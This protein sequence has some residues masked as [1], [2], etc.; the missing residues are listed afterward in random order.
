MQRVEIIQ[1]MYLYVIL[2][3]IQMELIV[4]CLVQTTQLQHM[5]TQP[6]ENAKVDSFSNFSD[7]YSNCATCIGGS[8]ND[9]SS[10]SGLYYLQNSTCTSNCGSG[11]YSNSN[12]HQCYTNPTINFVNPSST[13]SYL[14]TSTIPFATNS[15]SQINLM[16][17][18]WSIIDKS[19][20]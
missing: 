13:A 2:V 19:K 17:F 6:Q 14:K 16:N 8:L 11:Y 5:G 12:T 9:C 10:C 4:N 15:I 1:K 3:T 20:S 7:C 18:T